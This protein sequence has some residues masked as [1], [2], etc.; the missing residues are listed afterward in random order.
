MKKENLK[1]VASNNFKDEY[2][3]SLDW[4]LTQISVEKINELLNICSTTSTNGLILDPHKYIEMAVVNS[5][6]DP[7]L[8]DKGLQN[9]YKVNSAEELLKKMLNHEEYQKLEEVILDLN[10]SWLIETLENKEVVEEIKNI[11]KG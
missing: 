4:E 1:Y 5:I 7:D 6:V 9:A 8:Q 10:L 11:L 2:G 3:Q